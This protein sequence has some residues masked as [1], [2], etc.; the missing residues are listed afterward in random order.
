[1]DNILESKTKKYALQIEEL[2]IQISEKVDE[3]CALKDR[4]DKE[5]LK[6]NELDEKVDL[7]LGELSKTQDENMELQQKFDMV[8]TEKR[9]LD[10]QIEQLERGK[11]LNQDF[12]SQLEKEKDDLE[13][14]LVTGLPTGGM[15]TPCLSTPH[16]K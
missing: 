8:D 5:Q 3:V 2:D 10:N 1:M 11:K 14:K 16:S 6:V 9:G 12:I 15:Q 4:L 13:K 7:L